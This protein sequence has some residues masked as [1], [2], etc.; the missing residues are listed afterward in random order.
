MNPSDLLSQFDKLSQLVGDTPLHH[1]SSLDPRPGVEIYAKL[2]WLQWGGSVKMRPAFNLMKEAVRRG[3]LHRGIS[4]LDSTSGNTG[5]AYA[6]I[7]SKVGLKATIIMP[8]DATEERKVLIRSLGADLILVPESMSSDEVFE[9][10]RQLAL[11]HPDKYLDVNQYDNDDNWQAHAQTTA[12]EIMSQTDERITHFCAGLGTCG[13]FVGTGR[14]LK[15]L[16]PEIQLIGMHVA[17][18]E[19]DIEGWKYL[20]GS[21]HPKIYDPTLADDKVYVTTEEAFAMV[22]TVARQE[23]WIISPSSGAALAGAQ[24]VAAGVEQGVVVTVLPDDGS[25][26]GEVLK[27]LFE[28]PG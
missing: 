13:T 25:K 9:Y 4:L 20:A 26:Y 22:R 16:N 14:K 18:K 28:E 11:D 2:E 10:A 24:K 21:R 8:E 15:Q 17:E 23:G 27:G 19:N 6:S 7:A 3:E 5:I 1:F 12:P